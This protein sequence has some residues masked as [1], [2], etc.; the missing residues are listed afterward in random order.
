MDLSY[1]KSMEPIFG[2]WH[3]T[4]LIGEGSFGKVFEIE[5]EDFGRTYKAGLKV[6][7]IPQSE[8]EVKSVLADGMDMRSATAY[9]KEFV[10]EVVD[11]FALMAQLKGNS[12]IVS[13]EDHAVIAHKDG[14]GWDILIR[15]E[16]L[17]P[18]L[19]YSAERTMSQDDILKLGIDICRAL[20]YCKT[21]HIIHRD[22]K[23][24]NIFIAPSGDYKLGDF[25]IARTVEKSSSGM[26]KKGTYTYMAPEVY[27]GQTYGASVDIYSLGIVLYR[28]CNHNRAPFLPSYPAPISYSDKEASITR[29][30]G[31]EPIPAPESGDERLKQIIL[32]ACAYAPQDRY[33]Q[34]EE[35]RR[36]L[37]AL[38]SSD[39]KT[40]FT[41]K[42]SVGH[43][44]EK[45]ARNPALQ[46]GTAQ[47]QTPQ[48][49][50]W[51]P[52][53]GQAGYGQAQPAYG[54]GEDSTVFL[55]EEK[56]EQPRVGQEIPPAPMPQAQMRPEPE[57]AERKKGRNTPFLIV[58]VIVGGVLAAGILAFVVGGALIRGVGGSAAPEPVDSQQIVETSSDAAQ[59][60]AEPEE[61][62]ETEEMYLGA[63]GSSYAAPPEAEPGVLNVNVP[64]FNEALF[65]NFR[66][67]PVDSVGAD[68]DAAQ[69]EGGGEDVVMFMEKEGY[70]TELFLFPEALS[71]K[72]TSLDFS[73]ERVSYDGAESY[74]FTKENQA[75]IFAAR[76]VSKYADEVDLSSYVP[77][78]KEFYEQA[79]AGKMDYMNVT[80]VDKH[81]ESHTEAAYYTTGYGELTLYS[82]VFDETASPQL[83][84]QDENYG[85]SW[86]GYMLQLSK[87]GLTA[88]YAP[89][90][91]GQKDAE[92]VK[93]IEG[94]ASSPDD[95]YQGISYMALSSDPAALQEVN[96]KDGTAADSPRVEFSA[97]NTVTVS[98]ER[99]VPMAEGSQ[100][101]GAG[102]EAVE[103][104]GSVTF[105]YLPN[106]GIGFIALEGDSVYKYQMSREQYK[107]SLV[108]FGE[109]SMSASEDEWEELQAI[110]GKVQ[111]QLTDAFSAKGMSVRIENGVVSMDADV[112]FAVNEAKLS[113]EG[114]EYLDVFVDGISSILT[115]NPDNAMY[116]DIA[117][118][119]HTD[120][121]GDDAYNL[122]LSEQRAQAV[123]DYCVE[124]EGFLMVYLRPVGVGSQD[125]IYDENGKE[126]RAA[127]RRV[128][129][130]VGYRGM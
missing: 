5:R 122:K 48:P 47:E 2:S 101:A 67:E 127:S 130:I 104:A 77:S 108:H 123:T 58:G 83:M 44:T 32:K 126:D 82:P 40:P 76:L 15:M 56:K 128:D 26:S 33:Q 59:P 71:G 106:P 4:R 129:F 96:F 39:A 97:E 73:E 92:S 112:L 72:S 120:S 99:R 114:K 31:G 46:G 52:Q 7:T 35:M 62:E 13:Y 19:D 53:A 100:N 93:E 51:Q 65:G 94:Y 38:L 3:I 124:R 102:A 116:I 87:N 121:T 86:D 18:L 57:M 49:E 119:G 103:E 91:F 63:G 95:V 74:A 29:R 61:P 43:V 28:L 115:E 9:Y 70:D 88:E 17:T 66:M 14:I 69:S 84:L 30:I 60:E 45:T 113:K 24:E 20:E 37:E 78:F 21:F 34:P 6:I 117:V 54:T 10:E 89:A 85:V 81:G 98:W 90:G 27:Q 68:A 109:D 25:G 118:V 105:R 50:P 64:S 16:L 11:E 36:D 12:N 1:Y 125:L 75:D 111:K 8:S 107:R 110:Q 55:F 41:A 42:P 23:P 79:I 80:Y 22:I